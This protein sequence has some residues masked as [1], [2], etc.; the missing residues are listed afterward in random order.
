MLK[1]FFFIF[2][3]FFFSSSLVKATGGTT[4]IYELNNGF[5]SILQKDT[6]TPL[7]VM[8]LWVEHGSIDEKDEEAGFAHFLEHLTFRS[9]DIAKRVEDLGGDINAYTSL[10]RTVYY[11]TLP[12]EH[13]KTGLKVLYDIF[14]ETSF[15]EKSFEEEKKVILEE[16]KRGYDNPQRMVYQKF[17]ETAFSKHP[18]KRPVIGFE[19][20]IKNAKAKDVE[21]FYKTHYVPESS[22]LVIVGDFDD[23]LLKSEISEI[24][25]KVSR[26]KS[27]E[28]KLNGEEE[29]KKPKVSYKTM[30]VESCYVMLGVPVSNIYSKH[31]PAI[32]VLSYIFGE[33]PTSVLNLKIKEEHQLVNYIYSYQMNLKDFGFFVVQ[34]NM[35]CENLEKTIDEITKI[36]FEESLDI[37]KE[38]L[39]KVIKNYESNYYFSKE[40]L[41]DRASDIGSSYHYFRDVEYSKKYI[42]SI[43]KVSI[44]DLNLVKNEFFKKEKL[45]MSF[46]IPER[47]KERVERVVRKYENISQDTKF[48]VLSLKNGLR[49]YL[50]KRQNN[51][52]FG[53]SILSLAGTRIEDRE[54]SGLS[55]F[56]MSNL[57]R[58]TKNYSY[59]EIHEMIENT[60]GSLS[61]FST[62]NLSG[63]KGKF[64]SKDF[65]QA[66]SII[67]EILKNFDPPN[68]ELEKT[69]KLIIADIKKKK[70]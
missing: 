1:K 21:I 41:A 25:G 5:K 23:T 20:T 67:E 2:L 45:I 7:I 32:D 48:K 61:G 11:L 54:N 59:K 9:K 17:F 40:K 44:D 39:K 34:A 12:K 10:D 14:Q 64:L 15:D 47:E 38:Q 35:A 42:D 70:E 58:G 27:G 62:K 24:F 63:I 6:I 68:E 22:Y 49:V 66:L 56:V 31:V 16:M 13:L 52:T 60:G 28:R 46:V 33:S 19:E 18:A 55:N 65:Y 8:Q 4:E 43:N 51:P 50:N 69:K 36:L 57:L 3:F 26:A 29:Y 37:K 30:N 53:I